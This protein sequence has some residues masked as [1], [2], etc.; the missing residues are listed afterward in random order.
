MNSAPSNYSESKFSAKSDNFKKSLYQGGFLTIWGQKCPPGHFPGTHTMIFS[1]K[2]IGQFPYQKLEKFIAAFGRYR[3]KSQFFIQKGVLVQKNPRGSKN[4]LAKFFSWSQKWY[5]DLTSCKKSEKISNGLGCRTGTH[6]C[7]D[8]RTHESEFIGFFQSLKTSRE[9][10]NM[11]SGK[12]GSFGFH[13][14]STKFLTK[15]K[16]QFQSQLHHQQPL[17]QQQQSLYT[18]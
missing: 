7:T 6:T 17:D 13:H 18:Y 3:L 9:P 12:T 4:F 10:I 15:T 16:F 8:E 14:K 1:K 5:G 2:T 11:F